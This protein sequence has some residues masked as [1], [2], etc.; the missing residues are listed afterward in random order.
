MIL[1]LAQHGPH[2]LDPLSSLPAP[3]NRPLLKGLAEKPALNFNTYLS[4]LRNSDQAMARLEKMFLDRPEPT[5]L[6]HFGDHQP[7]FNGLIREMVRSWPPAL[8]PYKD[9]LTYYM[10]KSNVPGRRLPDYPMLDIAHLPNMVLQAAGVPMDP[11]FSAATVLRERCNGLYTDCV[12]QDLVK[13]YH[14]WT[15]GHLHVYEE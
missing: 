15:F 5:V 2:D 9:Y 7:S 14:G 4:N 12:D 3:F 13:S 1:T 8:Q 10:I 11:Y 6:M